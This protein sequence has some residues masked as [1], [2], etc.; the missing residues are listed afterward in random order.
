VRGKNI[1]L[2]N[3]LVRTGATMTRQSKILKNLGAGDIYYFG[4]HGM[5]IHDHF[6]KLVSSLP[7]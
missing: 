3:N 5:C 1:L 4:F 6:E 7:I 2:Y